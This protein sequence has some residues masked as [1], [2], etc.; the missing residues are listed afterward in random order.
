MNKRS[1]TCVQTADVI[2]T[3]G[4][5]FV[6]IERLKFPLGLAL[7]GGH[8]DPGELPR[9]AASRE[10]TE[11]TGLTIT[12]LEFVT[13]RRNGRRDPRYKMS[14]TRV[15]AGT[16]SGIPRNEKGSTKVVLLSKKEVLALSPLRFVFDH[17][18]IL[19][20]FLGKQSG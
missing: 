6:L 13:R 17:H 8:V 1:Q 15:Y 19:M 11:E 10:F 3:L 16:A 7:P 5:K 4:K 20:Q 14:Q 9:E 12:P 18:E 2:A